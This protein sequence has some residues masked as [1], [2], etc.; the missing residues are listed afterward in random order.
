LL[1]K[2][3][4]GKQNMSRYKIVDDTYIWKQKTGLRDFQKLNSPSCG[5]GIPARPGF[6]AGRMPNAAVLRNWLRNALAPPQ[7]NFEDFFI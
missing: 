2:I 4:F 3:S 6:R 5:M 1:T 7:E